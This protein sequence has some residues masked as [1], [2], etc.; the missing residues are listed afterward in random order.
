MKAKYKATAG[1]LL[2]SLSAAFGQGQ[3][4]KSFRDDPFN[5]P[6]LS[7][8][9][10]MAFI[11][12]TII[13]L[14]IALVYVVRVQ[15]IIARQTEIERAVKLG[16]PVRVR[17]AWWQKLWLEINATVPIEKEHDIDTGHDFDG[18][19]ELDNHLPPWWKGLFYGTAIWAVVYLVIYHVTD[20][21][22]LSIGEYETEVAKAEEDT[23]KLQASR[24]AELIDE[25]KLE[26][27]ADQEILI[28]GKAVFTTNNC[29][30]CHRPDGGGN[31]VGPNLTDNYWLHGGSVKN[32][33][34]T[35]NTGVVEKGMP[36][37][38]KVMSAKDV[39]DVAF[40][41]MSLKGTNPPNPKAPQGDLFEE[42][43]P[44]TDTTKVQALKK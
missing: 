38:G 32:I 21:L 40:Y 34:T 23:R 18:I 28:R 3:A 27:S 43:K 42:A 26:Y 14:V 25:T 12:I 4:P 15:D 5:S 2:M 39:R 20:T 9:L 33:F 35:I 17:K 11:G 44:M 16:M 31:G 22:P 19:R 1:M 30:S 13:L 6:M 10:T 41:I 8:Y 36:A 29:G 24:P 7:L 37:W